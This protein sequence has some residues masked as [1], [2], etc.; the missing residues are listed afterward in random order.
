MPRDAQ[1]HAALVGG[2]PVPVQPLL[3]QDLRDVLSS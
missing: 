1:R 3:G 2:S